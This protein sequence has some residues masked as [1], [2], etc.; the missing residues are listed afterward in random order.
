MCSLHC[1]HLCLYVSTHVT[2]QVWK[3][4]DNLH[5][6]DFKIKLISAGSVTNSITHWVILLP[7]K[8]LL[9]EYCITEIG[10]VAIEPGGEMWCLAIINLCGLWA[11]GNILWAK[12]GRVL[13]FTLK[14][15]FSVWNWC[16]IMHD[17]GNMKYKNTERHADMTSSVIRLYRLKSTRSGTGLSAICVILWPIIWVLK[18]LPKHSRLLVLSFNVCQNL[19]IRFYYLNCATSDVD[20][21]AN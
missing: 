12:Y 8:Y 15:C 6:M 21:G 9:L 16:W 13:D 10:K 4:E 20:L 3:S 7:L 17:G 19:K 1:I 11:G 18:R 14:T 2:V 5:Q